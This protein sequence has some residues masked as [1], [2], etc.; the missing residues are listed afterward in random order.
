MASSGTPRNQLYAKI[1][2]KGATEQKFLE[3]AAPEPSAAAPD[4]DKVYKIAA[5][6]N[7]PSKGNPKAKVVIQQFSDFQCP[8][9]TRVEPTVKQIVDTYG[10]K[11]KII[12]R[13][14]PLP[15]HANA[16]PAAEAASE[17]FAQGGSDKFWKYHGILFEHQQ[18]LSRADLEKYAE[19]VGGINMAKF[20]TA[21][22]TNKHK[23]SVQADMDAV[24]KAGARIGTPSFFI[25]GKLL[26]GAQPF[27]A[28]K[29]E[30]D[31]AL[32]AA[33]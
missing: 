22:D 26:Q 29:T 15:F 23:A 17:V 24:E 25:N 4:A 12:W 6:G 13:N 28:F 10:D 16:M 20:K 11:V 27:D 9:C 2:D 19:E 1:I 32:A 5:E 3:G 30:I 18:A 21:L 33:K 8:F 7:F 14:Y 31:K